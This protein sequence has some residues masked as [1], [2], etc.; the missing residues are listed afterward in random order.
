MLPIAADRFMIPAEPRSGSDMG[1][2][3][4]NDRPRTPG[5]PQSEP[6]LVGE[7]PV[8][9][10]PVAHVRS[11]L[12]DERAPLPPTGDAG[13]HIAT[14]DVL[15]AVGPY[16]IPVIAIG[17]PFLYVAGGD[18]LWVVGGVTLAAIALH[19]LAQRVSFTFAEGFLAFRNRDEWPRGVQEEYDVR[20]SW[21]P[22]GSA[23]P[24]S[25]ASR[26]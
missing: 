1:E 18:W 7:E 23:S 6:S 13:G 26:S 20:Y 12:F 14:F 3:R 2:T 25:V 10:R 15:R 8:L 22:T 19:E 16:L 4:M 5:E 24:G 9:V 17:V 11:P 21:P